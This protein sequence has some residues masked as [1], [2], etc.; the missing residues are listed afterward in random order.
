MSTIPSTYDPRIDEI[1]DRGR[2]KGKVRPQQRYT[3]SGVA[4]GLNLL[5]EQP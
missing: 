1:N 3:A 4:N 5:V 2:L